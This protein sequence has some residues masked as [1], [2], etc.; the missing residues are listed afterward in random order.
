VGFIAR[1]L[2]G[3]IAGHLGDKYGR[4]GPLVGSMVVMGLATASIGLLP[5]YDQIGNWGA[6]LL[7]ICRLV[8][9]LGVGAQ[10]GGAALLLTEHAPVNR[11]G[12]YGSLI[13][14]GT[15]LGVV[16][17]N[18]FFLIIGLFVAQEDFIAWGWR[19]PFLS[20]LLLVVV[21]IF[22]QLKI[23]D[24]PVFKTLQ[25]RSKAAAA[26][27]GLKK[28][29]LVDAVRLY[30]RQ[31]LQAAGAFFVVN[32]TFYILISGVLSYGVK[33]VGLDSTTILV[34]VLIG[35]SSQ[36]VTIPFFGSLSDRI[37]RRK[38]YL[39]GAVLMGLYAFPLFWLVDTGNVVLITL[40]LVIGFTIHAIMFGP[41]AALFAEMF[42]ADVRYS[43]A[44]LGFQLASVFA[45]GLAPIVMTTLIAATGVSWSVSLY[46][47]GMA[48]V[49]WFAVFTIRERF[50]TNLH[51]TSEELQAEEVP[52]PQEG[53]RV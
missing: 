27:A 8:Q 29:P 21:G 45:G 51:L 40:G 33:Q 38:L 10:W 46:I 1:P 19:V 4:K 2:G 14:M 39:T 18:A 48:A 13:Q 41:Q 5:G 20:G 12:F 3:I 30:W 6:V 23:E 15:I 26:D 43:G 11:R 22:V 49:T 53:S 7:I 32:A 50:R 17:G 9:G 47:V 52:T 44:S 37:G 34:C 24:T 35:V 28:A 42:P 36:V 31:I 16:I 25:A